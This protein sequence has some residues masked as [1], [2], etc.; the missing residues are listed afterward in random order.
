MAD[1]ELGERTTSPHRILR[2]HELANVDVAVQQM[3][4]KERFLAP[5]HLCFYVARAQILYEHAFKSDAA[6]LQRARHNHNH[7]GYESNGNN[8]SILKARQEVD[9]VEDEGS[10]DDDAHKHREDKRQAI[11]PALHPQ[12][13]E[14]GRVVLLHH[15]GTQER[16]DEDDGQHTRNGIGIPMKVPSWQHTAREGKHKREH[17]GNGG[18]RKDAVNHRVHTHLREQSIPV[19]AFY[20]RRLVRLAQM[21]QPSQPSF[22]HTC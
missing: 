3:A 21:I 1:V 8:Q 16:R 17:Q 5:M 2:H 22:R 4:L 7:H 13:T 9:N 10:C 14:L 18:T 6:S 19:A 20:S 15:H 12:G 11:Q